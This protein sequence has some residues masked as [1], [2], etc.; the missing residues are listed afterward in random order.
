MPIQNRTSTREEFCKR[1]S[2]KT[3]NIKV[4]YVIPCMG[5]LEHVQRTL[6]VVAQQA[7][8][9][10]VDYSCPQHTG[11]WAEANV[12]NVKVIRILGETEFSPSRARNIGAKNIKTE[13]VAFLD[14]DLIVKPSLTNHL[15]KTLNKDVFINF[16]TVLSNSSGYYGFTVVHIDNFNKVGG[17]DEELNGW[18][19]EDHLLRE[20]LALYGFRQCL[21]PILATHIDHTI[22]DRVRFHVE[23]D[24][25]KSNTQNGLLGQTI[26][27]RHRQKL[28]SNS[29]AINEPHKN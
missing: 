15:C 5:R 29:P 4:T 13:Y 21:I 7:E 3:S 14:A 23:K 10:L 8:C 22:E 20:K 25:N 17:Y 16:R 27:E 9:V 1:L 12:K 24:I 11:D 28:M 6:P 18:G 2:E 19:Y 26:L